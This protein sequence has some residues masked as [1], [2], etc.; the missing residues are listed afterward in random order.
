MNDITYSHYLG[1]KYKEV[2]ALV[3][4]QG[5]DKAVNAADDLETSA[6]VYGGGREGQ[7]Y[8]RASKLILRAVSEIEENE[9]D[10]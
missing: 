4:A 7:I 5:I 10:E 1:L 3:Q 8:R 9:T 6:R 2:L